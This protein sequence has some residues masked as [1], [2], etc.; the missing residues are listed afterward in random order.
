M[1]ENTECLISN[2][3]DSR[4]ASIAGLRHPLHR[5]LLAK[6]ESRQV[7]VGIIG[8]GYV[9]LPLARAF[10]D[11]G[12]EVLGFDVDATKVAKLRRGESYIGH[13]PDSTIRLM[14]GA[15]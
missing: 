10:C 5:A 14:R 1:S 12:I 11:G 15:V 6:I 8:L 9:G 3:G 13:I 4:R 2:S 7:R